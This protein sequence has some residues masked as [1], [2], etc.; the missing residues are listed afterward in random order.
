[1]SFPGLSRAN[2]DMNC[3][4]DVVDDCGNTL[5]A[6]T[7]HTDIGGRE[8]STIMHCV[9]C[10]QPLQK[11]DA[12]CPQCGGTLRPPPAVS[13]SVPLM[14]QAPNALVSPHASGPAD[15][16]GLHRGGPGVPALVLGL[17]LVVAV[18][19]LGFAVLA[20]HHTTA[21]PQGSAALLPSSGVSS[22]A[23]QPVVSASPSDEDSGSVGSSSAT[24]E[25]TD[26]DRLLD[27]ASARTALDNE[28]VQDRTAAEQLVGY[29]VP[30]LSSKRP[31]MSVHGVSYDYP[32]I[33]ADFH[34]LRTNYPDALLIWSGNYVSFKSADFY[35]TVVP[36]QYSDGQSA[37]EWCDEAGLA[38]EDCY[39][40][41]L[42]HSGD[43]TGTTLIRQ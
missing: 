10:G 2:L 40:K 24:Q 35:V 21:A 32:E 37:N 30:Q 5:T 13:P 7:I 1:L 27:S 4:L 29:W 9:N 39:A 38:P 3:Q 36:G 14:P 31:G 22:A 42:S 11:S 20:R 41:F 26:P 18:A 43:S 17:V 25:S 16:G 12:F 8:V 19:G 28:V 6:C 23:V 15:N 33:W 34:K